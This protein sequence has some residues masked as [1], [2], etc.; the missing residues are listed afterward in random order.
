LLLEQLREWGVDISSRQIESLLAKGKEG[1]HEEK[2]T[3]LKAGLEVSDYITEEKKAELDRRFEEIF[4]TQTRFETLNQ[5]LKRLH[6]NKSELLRVLERPEIP[7]HT[8]SSERDIGDYVKKREVSGG[9]RSDLGRC[10]RDTFVS[11]KKTTGHSPIYMIPI[12]G[13]R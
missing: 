9:T 3:I 6:Q 1:F 10:C 4:T 7:L 8:T 2:A 11:L 12:R 5:V 13:L